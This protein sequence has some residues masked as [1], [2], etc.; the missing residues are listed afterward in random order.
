M[1]II[2][3]KRFDID[4]KCPIVSMYGIIDWI[5]ENAPKNTKKC[6]IVIDVRIETD[7]G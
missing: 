7:D 4:Y 6:R 3:A 2:K 5:S 1:S